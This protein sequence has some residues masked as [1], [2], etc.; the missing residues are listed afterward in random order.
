MMIKYSAFA[1]MFFISITTFAQN[2]FAIIGD[3]GRQNSNSQSV[4]RSILEFGVTQLVMPGDNLYNSTYEK[5]WQPWINENFEFSVVAIGN[6]NSGYS[7]EVQ[8]FK[9][10]NEYYKKSL[11]FADFL[12]LNS[13]NT[14]NIKEQ[15]T[16]LEQELQTA[17]P[18]VFLV[19][20]HPTYTI[21]KV[22]NWTEKKSFQQSLSPLLKKYRAKITALIVGHDHLA[23][24]I[25]FGDLPVIL[26]GAVQE[27][28]NDAPVDYV[29]DGTRIKTEWY[30]DETPHWA[31]LRV[32]STSATVDFIKAS[33]HQIQCT[34]E[35]TIN[36]KGILQ[37][38]CQ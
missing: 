8:F 11:G 34:V 26:S 33:N 36:S 10:P 19:Y 29:V 13:D 15:I 2:E 16:W 7:K 28:R 14:N 31:R 38:N 27:V 35:L 30:F 20:H 25:H 37:S 17:G 21:S 23:S 6:H 4:M 9:M 1:F 32:S 22:H 24:L 5:V 12:V 3:A 18:L